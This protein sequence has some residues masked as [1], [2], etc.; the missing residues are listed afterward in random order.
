[1]SSRGGNGWLGDLGVPDLDS[2][3]G[4]YKGVELVILVRD[5][6]KHLSSPGVLLQKVLEVTSNGKVRLA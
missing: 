2:V 3:L 1:M 5:Q 4:N 6:G